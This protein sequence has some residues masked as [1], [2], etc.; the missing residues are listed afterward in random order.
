LDLRCAAGLPGPLLPDPVVFLRAP[1]EP[2]RGQRV[3]C[4]RP[5]FRL[6]QHPGR[7]DEEVLGTRERSR[8]PGG[9]GLGALP[10]SS[11]RPSGPLVRELDG[12]GAA[13]NG[14]ILYP[15]LLLSAPASALAHIG[16]PTV[17]FEGSAGAYPVRVVIRP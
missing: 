4:R 11:L 5:F 9:A 6:L 16:S 14:R 7:L 10:W 13:V 1:C 12:A 3:L 17:F 8:D 2:R 15:L